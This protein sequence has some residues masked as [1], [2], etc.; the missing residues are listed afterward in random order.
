MFGTAEPWVLGMWD[1]RVLFFSLDASNPLPSC[2]QGTKNS[3]NGTV[4]DFWR[5]TP[6]IFPAKG[7][8]GTLVSLGSNN[9]LFGPF[10][11][12][13]RLL[14]GMLLRKKTKPPARLFLMQRI[15]VSASAI[16]LTMIHG[17]L[18]LTQLVQRECAT[19][20]SYRYRYIWRGMFFLRG[21]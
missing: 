12:V 14:A 2:L 6:I 4:D 18:S 1:N 13:P 11:M 17:L 7:N 8:C 16:M 9:V 10:Q 15:L 5:R 20:C 3:I 19:E 21:H